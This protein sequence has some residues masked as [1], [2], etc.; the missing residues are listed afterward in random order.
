[1]PL[2]SSSSRIE[3]PEQSSRHSL[4]PE[5]WLSPTVFDLKRFSA[6][7]RVSRP[8]RKPASSVSLTRC[9]AVCGAAEEVFWGAVCAE[10]ACVTASRLAHS[11]DLIQTRFK[12][13]L[14]LGPQA[15]TLDR[16][17][18]FS[19]T[20]PPHQLLDILP[21]F[22]LIFAQILRLGHPHQKPGLV[23]MFGPRHS[24]S[25]RRKQARVPGKQVFESQVHQKMARFGENSLI[26]LRP[27][28]GKTQ[29]FGLLL[30]TGG[31][32]V[33]NP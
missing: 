13:F 14:S 18:F 9:T 32:H 19:R 12:I 33:A 4:I 5:L 7:A 8:G 15:Q 2:A 3:R 16:Q 27:E 22:L 21:R 31:F 30:P 23:R 17:S 6:A 10:P 11:Q 20:H 28:A 1:M 24:G 25:F 29:P 26:V